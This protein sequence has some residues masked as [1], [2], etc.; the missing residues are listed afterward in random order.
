MVRARLSG[1]P[2]RVEID[3]GAH[4]LLADEA[5][6]RGG[7]GTGPDPFELVLSGLAACTVI[8]LRMYADRKGW[9]GFSVSAELTHD[10]EDGRHLI[11]RSVAVTGVPDE[12]GLARLR[13]IVERTPVTLALKS[14]FA[15]TTA[16]AATAMEGSRT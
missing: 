16:V 4:A 12:A 11:E 5:T 8:T 1:A 3:A 13:D 15:I 7:G 14:G 10:V 9:N 2:Y 6:A